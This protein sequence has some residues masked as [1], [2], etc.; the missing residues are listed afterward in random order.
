MALEIQFKYIFYIITILWWIMYYCTIFNF[1]LIFVYLFFLLIFLSIL[2]LLWII[3]WL[4]R[5]GYWISLWTN[6]WRAARESINRHW[7][8]F[9]SITENEHFIISFLGPEKSDLKKLQQEMIQ[10]HRIGGGVLY[11]LY[12]NVCENSMDY[13]HLP[14]SNKPAKNYQH[15]F[16]YL[17]ISLLKEINFN[18]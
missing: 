11:F 10:C 13:I 9:V 7:K 18:V 14:T 15:L 12:K 16:N 4:T 8:G 2:T 17:F 6:V 1:I 5:F 3:S